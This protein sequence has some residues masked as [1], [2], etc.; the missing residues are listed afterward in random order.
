MLTIL[1]M[2]FE[3]VLT[4]KSSII[5]IDSNITENIIR[6][7]IN[8]QQVKFRAKNAALRNSSI[9][10]IFLQRLPIQNHQKP[11]ITE[12]RRNN[13]NDLTRNSIRLLFVKKTS[14]PNSGKSLGYIKC[15]KTLWPLFI[16]GV[17]CLMD[18]ATSR[19]HFRF[20]H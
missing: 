10:W 18:S 15:Y 19:R 20:Y 17:N 3:H 6:K 13:T 14:M 5:S 2:F 16:N 1:P 11:S 4:V 7:V 12:K 8:V 9:T